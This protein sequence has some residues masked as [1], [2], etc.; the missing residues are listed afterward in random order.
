MD[1]PSSSDE[2]QLM[3]MQM[4]VMGGLE[5][6]RQIREQEQFADIPIIAMTANAMQSHVDE[7]LEVGMNDFISKPF[8]PSQ[9]YS[10]IHKWVTGA[11]DMALFNP[12]FAASDEPDIQIPG[13]IDG[14]DIRAGLRRMAG[15]K[16][17]YV[18]T[19]KSFAAQQAGVVDRIHKAID[20]NDIQAAHREAH[21][22]KGNAG[23]I[24]AHDVQQLAEKIEA[25]FADN[26]VATGLVL[27]ESLDMKIAALT[28]AIR[29]AISA[30]D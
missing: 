14:L 11:G 1:T 8:D 18:N 6:A 16:G 20:E 2:C 4:P 5:A 29:R 30:T 25:A 21:T 17:V 13:S 27:L 22:L 12:S 10:T 15:M 26:E 9:L 7:C 28:G 3:D 19:L 24:E 23:L